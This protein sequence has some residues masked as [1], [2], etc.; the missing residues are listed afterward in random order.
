MLTVSNFKDK[1]KSSPSKP[2]NPEKPDETPVDVEMQKED[3]FVRPKDKI[4]SSQPDEL[5]NSE[6]DLPSDKQPEAP[7][8]PEMTKTEPITVK[9]EK[10]ALKEEKI[11]TKPENKMKK[12]IVKVE[13]PKKVK[14]TEEKAEIEKKP[15]DEKMAEKPTEV[16]C[17]PPAEN[18]LMTENASGESPTSQSG[19]N[20]WV[21]F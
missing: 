6:V 8:A 21:H 20:R 18:K 19:S 11:V 1:V 7:P 13:N 3:D 17:T 10:S 2:E 14:K 16:T 9:I 4:P 15:E 12:P 5:M